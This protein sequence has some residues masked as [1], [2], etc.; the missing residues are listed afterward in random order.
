[1]A[2]GRPVF[3]TRELVG[4]GARYSFSGDAA[5]VRVWPRGQAQITPAPS[6]SPVT[7]DEGRLRIEGYALRVDP[8]ATWPGWELTLYWRALEPL[9]RV[10]KLSLRVV[11]AD[12]QPF[13]DAN[14]APLVADVF[15]LHQVSLTPEWLP[16]EMIRDVH[17]VAGSVDRHSARLLIVVYDAADATEIGRLDVALPA[18]P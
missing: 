11:D 12:G 6:V 1:V 3:L 17:Y 7:V 2:D 4:I 15:P 8:Y 10:M 14:G 9:Q 5:L 18:L 16:G 13:V